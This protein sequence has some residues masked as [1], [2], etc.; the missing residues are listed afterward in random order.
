MNEYDITYITIPSLSED[1]RGSIDAAIDTAIDQVQGNIS[2]NSTPT[3]RRLAYPVQKQSVGF[4]RT[5]QA[6]IDP[7]QI[8]SL[9]TE[10]KKT[11]GIIRFSILHTSRREEVS[12]AILDRA[13]KEQTAPKKVVKD[14]EPARE[15]TMSEVE[16]QIE[17][18]LEEE[19]K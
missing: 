14:K 2:F 7:A 10:L 3:R 1:D 15:V 9:R 19:V 13:S 6:S 4:L 16:S 11:K 12:P 8:E 17:K 18:A 5:I